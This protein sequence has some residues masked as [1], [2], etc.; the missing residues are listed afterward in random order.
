MILH[1]SWADFRAMRPAPSTCYMGRG[2]T[3]IWDGMELRGI[4]VLN[5]VLG[6]V[7]FVW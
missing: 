3:K 5:D 7:V 2:A 4:D 1:V 6:D